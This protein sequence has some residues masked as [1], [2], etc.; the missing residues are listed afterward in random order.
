MI[1][2]RGISVAFAAG[3]L[4]GA[5]LIASGMTRPDKIVG[6]LDFFGSW[7]ASLAFVM[8]GAVGVYAPLSRLI[9]RRGAPVCTAHFSVPG[10]RAIDAPLVVGSAIFGLGWGLAGFCPGPALTS[11]GAGTPNAFLFVLAMVFG[12]GLKRGLDIFRER[13][14]ARSIAERH[15]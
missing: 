10:R 15:A 11:L 14:Q 9:L 13:Q 8:V 7:D 12:F 5:G 1:G 6:F 2:R 3:I 4:F